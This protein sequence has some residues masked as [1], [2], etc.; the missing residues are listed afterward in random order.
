SRRRRKVGRFQCNAAGG[1][2]ALSPSLL[3]A[4]RSRGELRRIHRP[5]AGAND[6]SYH[7]SGDDHF[8]PPVQLAASKGLVVCNRIRLAQ[9]PRTYVVERHV[10]IDQVITDTSSA[11]F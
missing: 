6:C 4:L 1:P 2:A 11:L 3:A 8:Y 7:I 5:S 10:G 9:T